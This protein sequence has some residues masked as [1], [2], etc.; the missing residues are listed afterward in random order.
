MKTTL[1]VTVFVGMLL[2]PA[3][4]IWVSGAGRFALP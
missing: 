2:T 1:G 3:I 4:I